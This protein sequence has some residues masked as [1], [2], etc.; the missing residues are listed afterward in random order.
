MPNYA[1]RFNLSVFWSFIDLITYVYSSTKKKAVELHDFLDVMNHIVYTRKDLSGVLRSVEVIDQE[2]IDDE[3]EE[4]IFK[5]N[6]DV[7][8]KVDEVELEKVPSSY[9]AVDNIISNEDA[10]SIMSEGEVAHLVNNVAETVKSHN[11]EV[12]KKFH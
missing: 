2:L 3:E 4:L 7:E 6:D 12:N 9:T 11:F 1:D 10:S 5:D 8:S